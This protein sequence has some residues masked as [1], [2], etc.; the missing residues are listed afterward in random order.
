[1]FPHL[2]PAVSGAVPGAPREDHLPHLPH[3]L[4]ARRGRRRRPPARLRRVRGPGNHHLAKIFCTQFATRPPPCQ[5]TGL[6]GA[7]CTGCKSRESSAVARCFDCSNFLCA[8]CVMAHQVKREI[9]LLH[10]EYFSSL[11]FH[12]Q[13]QGL[14]EGWHHLWSEL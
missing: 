10:Q 3:R 14:L 12:L 2:L 13:R 8:N 9:F 7:Y 6:E 1:M 4:P 11:C 5:D